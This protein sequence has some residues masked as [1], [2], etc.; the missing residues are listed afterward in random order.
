[1]KNS[2]TAALLALA[3]CVSGALAQGV[4][5]Q[6]ECADWIAKKGYSVDYIEQ[7]TGE[8]PAGNMAGD[9]RS[10]LEPKDAQPGD[11]VLIYIDDASARSQR[12][13]VVDEVLRH[14]DGSIRAFRTSSMNIGKLVDAAC[15]VTDNFGKVTQRTVNFDRV[16]R[17]RRSDRK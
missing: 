4:R 2:L 13:E 16:A 10:N 6:R 15:H 1:M 14:A 8:R 9:W 12:A 3:F 17:A 7:R 11:V 5:F